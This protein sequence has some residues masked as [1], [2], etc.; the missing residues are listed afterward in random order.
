[1]PA[2]CSICDGSLK[3]PCC[4]TARLVRFRPAAGAAGA[5]WAGGG[6]QWIGLA[7][8]VV[9]LAVAAG[10]VW[11]TRV[12]AS[13]ALGR[14]AMGFGDVT[15]MAMAGAWLGW[16]ACLL[17]AVLAVFIGLVHGI[18][19]LLWHSEAE[20]PFGPS[21]C[22]GITAV[23]VAWRPVWELAAPQFERPLEMALVAGLVIALTAV[24]LWAWARLR[25][26]ASPR[27]TP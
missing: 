13:W 26:P 23:V 6:D 11:A 1:M 7:T 4:G 5:A 21:L 15:L 14:E 25:P 3:M 16:Q 10:L 27:E 17:A 2:H 24:T 19:Q 20:L 8:A 18:G 22:L 12:G 9:G